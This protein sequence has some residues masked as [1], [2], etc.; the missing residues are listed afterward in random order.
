[1]QPIARALRLFRRERAL[2]GYAVKPLL[3]GIVAYAFVGLMVGGAAFGIGEAIG[4]RFG[5][6]EWVGFAG[7]LSA[8]A[9]WIVFG[10]AIYLALVALISGFGFD[11]L[12]IE[13]EKREFGRAA[14]QPLG[15]PEGIGD[16]VGR[17]VLTVAL[18]LIALCG[19]PTVVI[20]FLVAAFLALMDFT[21]PAL[22]RRG[23]RLGNQF[24]AARRIPGALPFALVA[25][26]V[27]L[28]PVLNVLALPVLVAAGTILVAENADRS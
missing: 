24:G 9:L 19:S 12:S 28:V 3:W 11:R 8:F 18:G 16:G 22:L 27:V 2:W 21:A 4:S 15:F 7:L 17:A 25:G 23:S 10:G 26:I 13:V 20:P 6:R 1:M 5:G 14:G